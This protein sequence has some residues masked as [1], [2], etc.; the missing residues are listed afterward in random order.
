MYYFYLEA[1]N[2]INPTLLFQKYELFIYI[3]QIVTYMLFIDYCLYEKSRLPILFYELQISW[4]NYGY[5]CSNKFHTYSLFYLY[6]NEQKGPEK[7]IK[8]KHLTFHRFPFFC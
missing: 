2:V 3:L 1:Y 5:C 4:N 7:D 8:K 6:K